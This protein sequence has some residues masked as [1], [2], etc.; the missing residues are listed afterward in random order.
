MFKMNFYIKITNKKYFIINFQFI[1]E[2]K[3]LDKPVKLQLPIVLGTYPFR[4]DDMK[5]GELPASILKSN[6]HYPAT[7]PIFRPWLHDKAET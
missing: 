3:S 1:I 7:L 6:T 2:P 5:E 4:T